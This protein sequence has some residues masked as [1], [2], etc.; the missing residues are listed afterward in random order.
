MS[1]MTCPGKLH[2]FSVVQPACLVSPSNIRPGPR[3]FS[4][5][6]PVSG[7]SRPELPG[8]KAFVHPVIKGGI[9]R[10]TDVFLPESR[11]HIHAAELVPP[12]KARSGFP[13]QPLLRDG[14]LK[15]Q[16]RR[17]DRVAG[18][19]GDSFPK[20][21]NPV[22]YCQ[23]GC[24]PISRKPPHRPGQT[25]T[26]DTGGWPSAGPGSGDSRTETVTQTFAKTLPVD[27]L[28]QPEGDISSR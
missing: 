19:A 4:G 14:L 9:R 1:L 13:P 18:V 11:V 26:S 10:E 3:R 17:R 2:S 5:D 12:D 21:A 24:S 27:L 6:P 15:F 28:G 8:D 25:R 7:R 16:P 23:Y 22:I 20:E